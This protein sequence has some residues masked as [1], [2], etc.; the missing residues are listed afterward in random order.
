VS[1]GHDKKIHIYKCNEDGAYT[2]LTPPL[3]GHNAS[4]EALQVLPDGTIV[5]GGS[6][7][8]IIVWNGVPDAS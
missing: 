7:H 6:D 1:G 2:H 5:S 4:I 8:K 3:E